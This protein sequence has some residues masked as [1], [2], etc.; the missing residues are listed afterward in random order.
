[1]RRRPAGF[2]HPTDLHRDATAPS[3]SH[4]LV[5]RRASFKTR[6]NSYS[7][8][9]FA[10][11]FTLTR[12]AIIND[13]LG[14]FSDVLTI[15]GRAAAETEATL[16]A[17]LLT[18]N[19][20]MDD[21]HP[22]FDAT[23]H[24]NMAT[25]GNAPSVASM[26]AGRLKMRSQMDLDGTTPISSAPRYIVSGP[27][28]ETLIEQL[29]AQITPNQTAEVNPFAGKLTPLTDPRLSGTAWYLFADPA[30]TPTLEYAGLN[31]AAGPAM[32]TQ[33]GWDVLGQAFRVYHDFG[34][35][36]VDYRG[37]Y[38]DPGA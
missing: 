33:N 11:Q 6:K 21:T 9:T 23:N 37:A 14:A 28:Q 7:L 1:M 10:K 16:L 31:G 26:S 38:M 20:A 35:G 4:L 19:P 24:H 34:A 2:G 3:R 15:M 27:A 12:Q 30:V 13:D 5:C 32:E 17:S 18:S 8:S 36:F 29:L 22:L 25:S